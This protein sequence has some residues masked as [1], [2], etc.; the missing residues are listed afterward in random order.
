MNFFAFQNGLL[1]FYFNSI[2]HILHPVAV[3]QFL[4]YLVFMCMYGA[5]RHQRKNMAKEDFP[6]LLCFLIFQFLKL[7][8]YNHRLPVG[9]INHDI[10]FKANIFIFSKYFQFRA[11]VGLVV[12]IFAVVGVCYWNDIRLFPICASQ[13]SHRLAGS[14]LLI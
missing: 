9:H 1:L 11:F 2:D 4:C 6:G 10:C 13:S 5:A 12:N 14:I 7:S 8:G 3:V